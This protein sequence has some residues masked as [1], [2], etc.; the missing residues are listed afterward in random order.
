MFQIQREIGVWI[1][2]PS[3]YGINDNIWH[4]VI[5]NLGGEVSVA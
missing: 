1:G 4:Q 5:V 2:D 3:R